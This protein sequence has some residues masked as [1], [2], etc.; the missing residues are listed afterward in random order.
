M[1][2]PK[3]KNK[4]A[5]TVVRPEMLIGTNPTLLPWPTDPWGLT[6]DLKYAITQLGS[7]IAG[8]A[9]K[10]ALVDAVL[11]IGLEHLE[12]KYKQDAAIRAKRIQ[13]AKD[14]AVQ[15]DASANEGHSE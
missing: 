13:A 14:E 11:A 2:K 8:H 10:K 7:R 9:D 15:E 5:D 1:A 6:K 12:L 3:N 4:N